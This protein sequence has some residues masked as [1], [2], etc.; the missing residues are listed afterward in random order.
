MYTAPGLYEFVVTCKT[1]RARNSNAFPQ[2]NTGFVFA[3]FKIRLQMIEEAVK[4]IVI[5]SLT[6]A[7]WVEEIL[8]RLLQYKKSKTSCVLFSLQCVSSLLCSGVK[9]S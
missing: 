6:H 8:I 9:P 2:I 1:I 3:C 4:G 5:S 7:G